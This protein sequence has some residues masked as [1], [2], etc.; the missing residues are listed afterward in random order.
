MA[1]LTM[2]AVYRDHWP[3][4]QRVVPMM[5]DLYHRGGVDELS[6]FV[7]YV[8]ATQRAEIRQWFVVELRRQVPGSGGDAMNYVEQLIHERMQEG[9][10]QARKEGER[11]R[12]VGTIEELL[13]AG[14]E[15]SIIES[16]TGIDRD[17]LRALKQQLDESGDGTAEAP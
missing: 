10:R 17:A 16:A 2:L 6:P 8:L 4:L 7:I 12:R 11:K 15:W 5:A 3:V 14:V 1:Q 9:V 13:R